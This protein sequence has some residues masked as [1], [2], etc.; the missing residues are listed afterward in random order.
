M[1]LSEEIST[2]LS[3]EGQVNKLIEEATN[4]MNL[5]QMFIGW[6]AWM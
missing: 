4:E 5:M 2:G 6:M 1:G 3:V